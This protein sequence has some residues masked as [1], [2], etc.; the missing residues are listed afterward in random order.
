MTVDVDLVEPLGADTLVYGHIGA[1]GTGARVAVRLHGVDGGP[2]RAPAGALRR[3]A[4]ALVRRGE[5]PAGG[6]LTPAA[7]Q[8]VWKFASRTGTRRG[9][10]GVLN[11]SNR[12]AS[13]W[14]HSLQPPTGVT[15]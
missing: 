1:N 4:R 15:R 14:P 3:R 5:R 9:P 8:A 13:A 2:A 10:N 12:P 6:G 7:G 11:A